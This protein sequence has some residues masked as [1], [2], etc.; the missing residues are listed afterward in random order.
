VRPNPT[1]AVQRINSR[2]KA[3]QQANPPA[4]LRTST[5]VQRSGRIAQQTTTSNTKQVALDL[6]AGC[7]RGIA[8]CCACH[9]AHHTFLTSHQL[10][11]R[12]TRACYTGSVTPKVACQLASNCQQHMPVVHRTAGHFCRPCLVDAAACTFPNRSV[13]DSLALHHHHHHHVTQS[14]HSINAIGPAPLWT[15]AAWC[16]NH[17]HVTDSTIILLVVCTSHGYAESLSLNASQ[18]H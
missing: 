13:I 6:L 16:S 10:L 2:R 14:S 1:T 12:V 18:V 17:A 3:A 15:C 9:L 11:A 4:P 5:L 8:Q 7:W